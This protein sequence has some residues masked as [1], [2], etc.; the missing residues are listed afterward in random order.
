MISIIICITKYLRSQEGNQQPFVLDIA[1]T[2]LA[3]NSLLNKK[4]TEK[5]LKTGEKKQFCD[6]KSK[7]DYFLNAQENS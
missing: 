5:Q 1:W 6:R 3:L 2:V 7:K 4:E